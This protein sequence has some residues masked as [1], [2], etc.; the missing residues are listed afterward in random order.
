MSKGL[1]LT[2]GKYI[3]IQKGLDVIMS[4]RND[5]MAF[6]TFVTVMSSSLSER[7]YY[8]ISEGDCPT[9][10]QQTFFDNRLVLG[11]KAVNARSV[12]DITPTLILADQKGRNKR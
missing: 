1:I 11:G 10:A 8:T 6:R 4:L 2:E 7:D 9:D 12:I 3:S 5:N